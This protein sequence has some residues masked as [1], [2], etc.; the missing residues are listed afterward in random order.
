LQSKYP[1]IVECFNK[2]CWRHRMQCHLSLN[3]W[4]AKFLSIGEQWNKSVLIKF[5]IR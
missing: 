3:L 1:S 5:N 2:L 4:T